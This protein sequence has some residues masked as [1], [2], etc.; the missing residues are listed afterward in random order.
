M[1]NY[2]I[3][4]RHLRK[5]FPNHAKALFTAVINNEEPLT[6][7]NIGVSTVINERENPRRAITACLNWS[8]YGVSY[9]DLCTFYEGKTW[10]DLKKD[11][12]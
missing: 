4:L 1:T 12:K 2:T 11:F 10:D 8:K 5:H 6:L 3:L 7:N 9:N